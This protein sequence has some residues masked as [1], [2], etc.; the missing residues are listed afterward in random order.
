[1]V[2]AFACCF[3]PLVAPSDC[4]VSSVRPSIES[5]IVRL[6]HERGDES[7]TH[8]TNF[9]FAALS[10]GR[11][12]EASFARRLEFHFEIDEGIE[13]GLLLEKIFADD[14]LTVDHSIDEANLLLSLV[15][16]KFT[17]QLLR[18]VISVRE[19][20]ENVPVERQTTRVRMNIRVQSRTNQNRLQLTRNGR[21][22]FDQRLNIRQC[23][24]AHEIVSYVRILARSL[25]HR[26]CCT[27]RAL[28]TLC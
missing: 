2:V 1:M 15:D 19:T 17:G 12:N 11:F 9:E 8:E 5:S 14:R 24:L 10:E 28:R 18:G 7:L 16:A 4:F 6:C 26:R 20:I 13:V 3:R 25:T 27:D 23:S 22:Q 21:F